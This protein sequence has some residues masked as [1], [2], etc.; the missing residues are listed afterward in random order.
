[1]PKLKID[2]I[3]SFSSEDAV[4]VANNILTSDSSKKWKCQTAGEKNAVV[5]LQLEKA[6][7][8]SGIDIGNEHSAYVEVLV[9]RSGTTEDYKV[10][11]VASSFMT[12][13]EARQSQNVNK[14]R[15]FT[16]DH[17]SK[18]E[19]DEKW[20]RV[21]IVC[22]QPFNKHV[23]YGLSFI[24]IHA[25]DN[26]AAA[27]T[28][29]H[30]GKFILRPDSPDRLAA[31]SLFE[32]QKQQKQD[33][34]LTAAAAIREA[35]SSALLSL[36][37][38]PVCKP[39]LKSESSASPSNS[40]A[41]FAVHSS[42]NQSEE[43]KPRNRNELLY[44]KDEEEPNDKIDKI[45]E[46]KKQE[47]EM[48]QDKERMRKKK[49][50]ELKRSNKKEK[51]ENGQNSKPVDVSANSPSSSRRKESKKVDDTTR[52]RKTSDDVK[53]NATKRTRKDVIAKPFAK[54]L[55]GVTLVISGIQNPD[56]GNLRTLALTM[57]AKYKPDWDNTCTHLICAFANT[58]KFNQVKGKGKI[59]K[60]TWLEDC[61][62]QRKR[63]PWRRYAL[64]RSDMNKEESEDEICEKIDSPSNN[65][66]VNISDSDTDLEQND[67]ASDTEERI[68]RIQEMQRIEQ[69]ECDKLSDSPD[70]YCADT[71][72]ESPI[73]KLPSNFTEN[74]RNL[75][76][77]KN[78]YID[79]SFDLETYNKLLKY[80]VAYNGKSVDDPTDSIDVIITKK[81][82]SESLNE[83][84]SA[85]TCLS[86]EW[87]WD[88]H[89]S[90]KLL[91]I[92]AYVYK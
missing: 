46:K 31:G 13:L 63:L 77:D 1:M 19:C 66:S 72:E 86:P 58:P 80:I 64:D 27:S 91:P 38:S 20:D 32:R 17:F 37:G 35:S 6:S 68:A 40:K 44:I 36:Y 81:E 42:E 56:R 10:L 9:S 23:Q 30:I 8:I 41:D 7:V 62:S 28:Q 4:H 22:T 45:M 50:E 34:K 14:V 39:K 83:V 24:N 67:G 87:V 57:G 21:K 78:F 74:L 71:D 90:Q 15:M 2:H 29:V 48:K 55:E 92:D 75:F 26:K 25:T 89:N 85:A 16:K 65:H 84:N 82:N 76:A 3:I 12:P 54:L 73:E 18:P 52:K 88:C 43:S 79:Q 49:E 70:I 69:K 47:D 51:G 53:R 60:R 5:V 59:V 33:E 61:H 11:L